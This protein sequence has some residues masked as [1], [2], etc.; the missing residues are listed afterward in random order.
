VPKILGPNYFYVSVTFKCPAE[1][2]KLSHYALHTPC[3]ID[4]WG[5]HSLRIVAILVPLAK[6]KWKK[7]KYEKTEEGGKNTLKCLHA[8]GKTKFSRVFNPIID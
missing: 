1:P 8:P 5:G 6:A 7:G 2:E 3:F 4:P